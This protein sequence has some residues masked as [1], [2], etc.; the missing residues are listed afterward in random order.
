MMRQNQRI[1]LGKKLRIEV[2]GGVAEV[3]PEAED[4]V[5][6]EV[7]DGDVAEGGVSRQESWQRRLQ[8]LRQRL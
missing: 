4:E 1:R 3:V 7:V 5:A 6:S 8:D 2:A